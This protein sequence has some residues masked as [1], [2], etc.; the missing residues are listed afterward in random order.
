MPGPGGAKT[1]R[2]RF[3]RQRRLK[4]TRRYATLSPGGIQNTFYSARL[5]RTSSLV[6]GE[7]ESRVAFPPRPRRSRAS[8][9]SQIT[10][11]RR[12]R[13]H[14]SL[15]HFIKSV[16]VRQKR[17]GAPQLP[18]LH[19]RGDG[20]RGLVVEPGLLR[21]ESAG[22][23][24]RAPHVELGVLV[25]LQAGGVGERP[26]RRIRVGGKG[27]RR[28]A[29]AVACVSVLVSVSRFSFVFRRR[30]RASGKTD[31]D[32][33]GTTVQDGRGSWARGRGD[34]KTGSGTGSSAARVSRVSS[35]ETRGVSRETRGGARGGDGKTGPSLVFGDVTH[36]QPW[37]ARRS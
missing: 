23:H 36:R 19:L 20:L 28:D 24:L 33:D 4:Q 21:V 2:R 8:P 17:P 3:F 27:R 25:L 30:R 26:R 18:R 5:P 10:G 15:F 37:L 22:A 34:G 13:I 9:A 6:S 12:T 29:V 32:A 7:A 35:R 1:I 16:V 31:A 14:S 11:P